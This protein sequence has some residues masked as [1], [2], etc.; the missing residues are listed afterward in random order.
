[1]FAT[2]CSTFTF[3]NFF[4]VL[5]ATIIYSIP[6]LQQHE[7]DEE[8]NIDKLVF[9]SYGSYC[10]MNYTIII[11]SIRD[12]SFQSPSSAYNLTTRSLSSSVK[13]K[14]WDQY[15]KVN[16]ISSSVYDSKITSISCLSITMGSP[17]IMKTSTSSSST[18]S[19]SSG[20]SSTSPLSSAAITALSILFSLLGFLFILVTF[21]WLYSHDYFPCIS[22]F[23]VLPIP[24]H[25]IELADARYIDDSSPEG[26]GGIPSIIVT[27]PQQQLADDQ[28]LPRAIPVRGHIVAYCEPV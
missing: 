1:M 13:D 8:I 4:K 17:H 23:K 3:T 28:Q 27:F 21:R 5:R 19:S 16:C 12:A 20:S 11:P 26:G 15:W 10:L 6:S 18:S 24:D 2:P 9:V 22:S 25:E 7:E 14:D